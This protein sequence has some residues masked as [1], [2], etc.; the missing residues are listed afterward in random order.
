MTIRLYLLISAILEITYRI[1]EY[2][3]RPAD[4]GEGGY[5]LV[6]NRLRHDPT[7]GL[8]KHLFRPANLNR[9]RAEIGYV[10]QHS[11]RIA[12]PSSAIPNTP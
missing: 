11:E 2:G 8:R 3:V 6:Y 4:T 9:V 10:I 12:S 5:T 7:R 1:N